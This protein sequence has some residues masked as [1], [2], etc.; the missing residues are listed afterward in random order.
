MWDVVENESVVESFQ[1]WIAHARG[2]LVEGRIVWQKIVAMEM[3]HGEG[4][5]RTAWSFPM[6]LL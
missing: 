5:G 1:A 3:C 2:E 6:L 4:L